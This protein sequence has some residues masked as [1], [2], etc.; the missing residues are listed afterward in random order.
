MLKAA[1]RLV[2][3]DRNPFASQPLTRTAT[4]SAVVDARSSP[5]PSPSSPGGFALQGQAPSYLIH[6]RFA[7]SLVIADSRP[8]SLTLTAAQ[9]EAWLIRQEIGSA[10]CRGRGCQSV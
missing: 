10:S 3:V 2:R 6:W 1:A 7:M 9:H 4:A 5:V 8:E